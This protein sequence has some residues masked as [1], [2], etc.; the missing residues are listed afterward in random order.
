MLTS[1][2]IADAFT[3]AVVLLEGLKEALIDVTRVCIA[4][5]MFQK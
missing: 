1:E 4:M 2:A 5:A 3:T